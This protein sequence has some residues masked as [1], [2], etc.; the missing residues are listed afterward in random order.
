MREVGPAAHAEAGI[1]RGDGRAA[2]WAGAEQF[3]AVVDAV[4]LA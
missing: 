4:P 3:R 2:P 1:G